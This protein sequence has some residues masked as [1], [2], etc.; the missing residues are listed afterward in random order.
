METGPEANRHLGIASDQHVGHA[1]KLSEAIHHFGDIAGYRQHVQVAHGFAASTKTAGEF[2]LVDAL[3]LEQMFPHRQ[4]YVVGFRPV[5]PFT[6]C[7][8]DGHAIEDRLFGLGRETLQLPYPPCL[9]RGLQ[10]LQ[11]CDA[12]LV[13]DRSSLLG[14]QARYPKHGQHGLGDFSQQL[15]QLRQL[16]R[17]D[18]CGTLLGNGFANPVNLQQPFGVVGH[19][20]RHGIRQIAYGAGAV[21]IGANAKRIRP[22]ELQQVGHLFE[23]RGYLSVVHDLCD[24]SPFQ[25]PLSTRPRVLWSHV[26]WPSKAVGCV[27][28]AL[29][30]HRTCSVV[31]TNLWPG[32]YKCN[33]TTS[34]S[35]ST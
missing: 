23:N 3:A 13:V 30:G 6:G 33:S 19:D 10:F 15:L 16:A 35:C 18:Q 31:S 34:L 21:A 20:R 12:Q 11:R 24:S 4:S 9:A 17:L 2:Q 5:D 32:A 22:L 1:G 26:R 14:P 29:E 25:R 7:F 8:G 27:S 28:T